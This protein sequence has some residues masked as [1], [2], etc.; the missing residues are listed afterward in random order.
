LRPHIVWF[1]ES[2]HEKDLTRCAN[3]LQAC[4]VLFVI[5]TSGVV[6]PAAGFASIARE[7]G[8]YVIEVN[9][10]PTPQSDLVDIALRGH[11]KELVPL[12]LQAG[13]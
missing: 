2:L 6:Y 1:G 8:A 10:D 12:L 3:Q 4:D 7:A 9:L 5:G 11:A 13:E